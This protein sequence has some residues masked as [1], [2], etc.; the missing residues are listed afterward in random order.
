MPQKEIKDIWAGKDEGK[1]PLF[2]DS[3][4]VDVGN[5]RKYALKIY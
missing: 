1:L 3:M 2:G 5:P 4:I